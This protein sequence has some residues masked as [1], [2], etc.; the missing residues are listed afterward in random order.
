[1][2]AP[3][4]IPDSAEQVLA[5]ASA[6]EL[7]ESPTFDAKVALPARGKTRDLAIDV[8]AMANDGGV[9][10][11]GVGEDANHRPTIPQPFVLKGQAERVNQV[12]RSGISEA[13]FIEVRELPLQ[14]NLSEGFL[15]VIVPASPRGPHMVTV[16]GEDRYY[17]RSGTTNARLTEGEVARL[18]AQR[19]NWDTDGRALLSALTDRTPS[20]HSDYAYLYVAAQPVVSQSQLLARAIGEQDPHFFLSGLVQSVTS[21]DT[22]PGLTHSGAMDGFLGRWRRLVDGWGVELGAIDLLR[23]DPPEALNYLKY[24]EIHEDGGAWLFVARAGARTSESPRLLVLEWRIAEFVTAFLAI[25]GVLYRCAG[26][27]G[28]L[29]LGIMITGLR[30]AVSYAMRGVLPETYPYSHENYV[31]TERRTALELVEPQMVARSMVMPLIETLTQGRYNP[32]PSTP[33]DR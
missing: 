5:A 29:D 31:R 27:I 13:P 28:P 12:V 22:F 10:L 25:I 32:F 9:L 6:G 21:E 7:V 24:V 1:M 8:A 15:V 16:D 33:N 2:I 4:W 26:F 19:S 30:G 23:I 3:M 11:Y 14:S 20:P 18:Y 17:G